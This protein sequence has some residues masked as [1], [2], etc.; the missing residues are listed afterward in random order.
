MTPAQQAPDQA[1]LCLCP[2]RQDLIW[3]RNRRCRTRSHRTLSHHR[4]R[5]Y[6]PTRDRPNFRLKTRLSTPSSSV[7]T[8]H[9]AIWVAS[10]EVNLQH[11]PM[12][13]SRPDMVSRRVFASQPARAR[14]MSDLCQ[15]RLTI[16]GALRRIRQLPVA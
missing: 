4:T 9:S 8:H 5:R 15:I 3:F 13:S 1:F 12:T 7:R 11:L 10:M 16:V 14:G 2:S 6:H